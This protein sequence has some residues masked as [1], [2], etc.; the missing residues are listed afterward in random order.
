MK[1]SKPVELTWKK[2]KDGRLVAEHKSDQFELTVKTQEWMLADV[3]EA[4]FT[5]RQNGKLIYRTTV[6]GDRR[7][8]STVDLIQL[9]KQAIKQVAA[10]LAGGAR[11]IYK[12][13]Y[14][15]LDK[16]LQHDLKM[17]CSNTNLAHLPKIDGPARKAFVL[18]AE[19]GNPPGF[20]EMPAKLVRKYDVPPRA[21]I[22]NVYLDALRVELFPIYHPVM[23]AN[24]AKVT[25]HH[26]KLADLL[27]VP[28]EKAQEKADK[29][30]PE[31]REKYKGPPPSERDTS[32]LTRVYACGMADTYPMRLKNAKFSSIY[33]WAEKL[34]DYMETKRVYL[35]PSAVVHLIE[36]RELNGNAARKAKA[37]RRFKIIFEKE[38]DHERQVR[39][40]E[41]QHALRAQVA[42]EQGE[43]TAPK[44]KSAGGKD[45]WG[46][47][48]GTRAA[49]VNEV[50]GWPPKSEG[51]IRKEIGHNVSVGSHLSSLKRKGLVKR[52]KLGRYYDPTQKPVE[53]EKPKKS[54][55]RKE[56]KPTKKLVKSKKTQK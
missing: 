21:Q 7:A 53:S 11:P 28:K 14:L 19:K 2:K 34:L 45:K 27:V 18:E 48:I 49:K 56:V 9:N 12:T 55:K 17:F 41:W 20:Y 25:Q 5:L 24:L 35:Y 13:L 33:K 50:I 42:K 4:T 52:T 32:K 8:V 15:E 54:K 31:P 37:V 10:L 29:S 40:L 39:D 44:A 16:K 46:Y 43:T 26:K 1:P 3:K 38:I 47:R 36:Q 6:S 51:Q 23:S 22:P 30:P